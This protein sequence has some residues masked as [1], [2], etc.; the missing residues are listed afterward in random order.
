MD[1]ILV[2]QQGFPALA[3][4]GSSLSRM[5]ASLLRLWTN[6]VVIYPDNTVPDEHAFKKAI[7][8]IPVLESVG[9]EATFPS[10]PY[11]NDKSADPADLIWDKEKQCLNQPE[12]LCNQIT[13]CRE[14]FTEQDEF[15]TLNLEE[16]EL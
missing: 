8:W 6:K 10:R 11:P 7:A 4:M 1:A 9:I 5:A 12:W 15:H 13:Y 16:V 2:R 3:V 14:N